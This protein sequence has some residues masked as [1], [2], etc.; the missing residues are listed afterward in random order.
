MTYGN[1]YVVQAVD[2][3]LRGYYYIWAHIAATRDIVRVL[4]ITSRPM[5]CIDLRFSSVQV[6]RE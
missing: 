5:K 4:N 2:I 1:M 3:G 6:S